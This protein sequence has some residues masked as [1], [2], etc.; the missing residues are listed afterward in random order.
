MLWSYRN[1]G[2]C[3]AIDDCWACILESLFEGPSSGKFI[4]HLS[5]DVFDCVIFDPKN[6][7]IVD[8]V[9]FL[10]AESWIIVHWSIYQSCQKVL[11]SAILMGFIQENHVHV[12]SYLWDVIIK[13]MIETE[14]K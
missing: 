13:V 2:L 6:N 1:V 12:F 4:F 5:P 10:W 14:K 11:D 9:E 3:I 8:S 7:N